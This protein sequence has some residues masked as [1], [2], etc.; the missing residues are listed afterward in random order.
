VWRSPSASQ[1]WTLQNR[2][3]IVWTGNS[4]QGI[5][6]ASESAHW[7]RF[8]EL[9]RTWVQFQG[10]KASPNSASTC[11]SGRSRGPVIW[12]CVRAVLRSFSPGRIAL[13]RQGNLRGQQ[14]QQTV[15]VDEPLTLCV[16]RAAGVGEMIRKER[17]HIRQTPL[18]KQNSREDAHHPLTHTDKQT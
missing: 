17:E 11:F 13:A 14:N 1:P 18:S 16:S 2:K 3:N 5:E 15:L 12:C 8:L 6:C 4:K 7:P 9:A 10:L